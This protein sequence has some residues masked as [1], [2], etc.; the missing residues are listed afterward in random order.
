MANCYSS[1]RNLLLGGEEKLIQGLPGASTKEK[2]TSTSSPI[3][4][5]VWTPASALALNFAQALAHASPS[6]NELFKQFMKAYLE[7]HLRLS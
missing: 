3:I 5:Q 2:N 1:C 4:S 7:S 6:T